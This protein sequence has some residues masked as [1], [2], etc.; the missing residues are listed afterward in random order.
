MAL[1]WPPV[2]PGVSNPGVIP[3][4]T[5]P[6]EFRPAKATTTA[7][8]SARY[9]V[10]PGASKPAPAQA[11]NVYYLIIPIAILA[12]VVGALMRRRR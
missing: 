7:P 9:N 12:F 3:K 1:P 4:L 2:L 8:P 5:I 11:H 6:F 10:K